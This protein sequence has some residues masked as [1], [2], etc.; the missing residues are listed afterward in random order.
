MILTLLLGIMGMALIDLF[1]VGLRQL[2][3]PDKEAEKRMIEEYLRQREKAT[4][5][6]EDEK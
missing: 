4:K 3:T 2:G 6:K 5:S 1:S